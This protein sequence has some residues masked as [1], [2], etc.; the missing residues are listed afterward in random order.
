MWE[1]FHL[2]TN[3]C[4]QC[5]VFQRESKKAMHNSWP[6]NA[7][8]FSMMYLID[9]N[10]ISWLKYGTCYVVVFSVW[11]LSNIRMWW[12]DRYFISILQP[13]FVHTVAFL[14]LQTLPFGIGHQKLEMVKRFT[15][16]VPTYECD[17]FMRNELNG[18]SNWFILGTVMEHSDSQEI[19]CCSA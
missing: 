14:I 13:D 4:T 15:L 7:D 11:V 2:N 12:S 1:N 6:L 10:T 19:S 5:H 18:I 9:A 3:L 16:H 17:D 8:V